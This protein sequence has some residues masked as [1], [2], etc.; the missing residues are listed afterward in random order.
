MSVGQHGGDA[1]HFTHS[2]STRFPHMPAVFR[3]PA[4]CLCD[5]TIVLSNRF[6]HARRNLV[7]QASESFVTGLLSLFLLL[8]LGLCGSSWCCFGGRSDSSTSVRIGIGDTVLKLFNLR[9][10]V[11]GLDSYGQNFLVAVDN[12]VHD[13]WEGGEVCGQRDRGNGGNGACEGLEQLRFLNVKDT[14]RKGV[15]CVVD[16]T[17]GHT[18]G[19]G[20]DVQH[21]QQCSLGCSDLAASFNKLQVGRNFNGTTG[22]FG[23]NAESLEERGLAGFHAS[24]T[25]WD[26][27]VAW[28]DGTGTS[29]GSDLV[30][31]NL[32]TDSLEIAVG[33]D[34]TNVALD[35]RKETFV[36]GGL[37]DEALDSS[38]H[39]SR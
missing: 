25:S 20:R 37:G 31:K 2:E 7:K 3:V 18:V 30:G 15:A 14:G 21:V 8:G 22:N 27:D 28:G 32:L 12:G 19:E 9:P 35:E 36:L 4:Y 10:A 16:L 11:L 29:G 26:E 39:L 13:G 38:A 6:I 33:E 24:V 34:E 23:W 5:F 17:D 1:C